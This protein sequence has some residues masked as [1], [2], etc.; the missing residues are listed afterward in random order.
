MARVNPPLI[1]FNR[2]RLSRLALARTDL[3]RTKLSAEV[4]TNF[5]PRALGSMSL[6]PGLEYIG[7]IA[8]SST[9]II[10]P[11]VFATNDTALLEMTSTKMRVWINDALVERAPSTAAVTNG[12]FAGDVTSWTDADE[13]GSTSEYYGSTSVVAGSSDFLSLV[14][15]RYARAIRQQTV[16]SSAG[17]HAVVTRVVRGRV[18]LRIGASVGGD[19]YRNEVTLRPGVY[20]HLITSTGDFTI[21]Y[22]ANT[23]YRSLVSSVAIEASGVM[24][25]DTTWASSDL[26]LLRW[27]QS[28][29]VVFVAAQGYPQK[30]LERYGPE[31][32]GVA[33]YEPQDGPFLGIN[34]SNTRLTPSAL[35]GD[36]D[37][38]ADRPFFRTEHKGALF[39]LT[40]IGQTVTA[41]SSL[42]NVFTNGIRV[43]GVGE[44][45]LFNIFI[46]STA[47]ITSTVRVQRSIGDE[48]SYANVAGL[49]YTGVEDKSTDFQD[50][51]DNQIVFYR[52]GIPTGDYV[53]TDETDV[54]L[55]YSAGGLAGVVRINNA[56]SSTQ[57]SASVLI[58]LGS[59][60]ATELWEEG[61]WSTFRG[62]PSAV[63][64][65][66][67]RLWWAGKARI[68][69][70]ISDAY[71]NFDPDEEGDGGAINKIIGSGPVDKIEW[72]GSLGTLIV[73]SQGEEL[74]AKT[75]SLEQPLTPTNFNLRDVSTQG[76]AGVPPVKIDS[77]MVFVQKSGLR[78][79]EIGYSIDALS[80]NTREVST[81]VPEIGEPGLARMA[82][83]RQP[84]TRVHCVRTST[85]G[86]VALLL[87]D[88]A[89]NITAW[90]DV[91]TGDAD[92]FNGRIEDVVILPSTGDDAVY[93]PVRR[94]ING[95]TQLYLEKMA[96][97]HEAGATPI[98]AWTSIRVIGDG[99]TTE[100]I[101]SI[102]L[103]STEILGAPVFYTGSNS[104]TADEV[105]NNIILGSYNLGFAVFTDHLDL[106]AELDFIQA[107]PRFG[108]DGSRMYILEGALSANGV[109]LV[110][111]TLST[112]WDV[113][114]ASADGTEFDI[115]A[116]E[117]EDVHDFVI[118]PDGTKLYAIG[119]A[120]GEAG[121][122]ARL[123]QYSFGT[124]FDASTLTSDAIL[125]DLGALRGAFLGATTCSALALAIGDDGQA[126]FIA[127]NVFDRLWKFEFNT[128]WDAS[129]LRFN[130]E[131]FFYNALVTRA[132]SVLF[133][134]NGLAFWL[135]D[136]DDLGRLEEYTL[137]VAWD[138][139]TAV[140]ASS[141]LYPTPS[142]FPAASALNFFFAEW[143]SNGCAL[144][145]AQTGTAVVS[146]DLP[147][148]VFQYDFPCETSAV[149]DGDHVI[150][151]GGDVG[152][153][154]ADAIAVTGDLRVILS[155]NTLQ[156][157]QPPTASVNKLVDSWKAFESTSPVVAISGADHLV[158]ET[159]YLWGNGKDLGTYTVSSTGTF[160]ASEPSTTFVYGLYYEAWFKS[161]KL[162]YGAEA[163]TALTQRKR[164]NHLG[165]ILSRTHAKGLRFGQTTSTADL[166]AM[167]RIENA[168]AISS[169]AIW[170]VY[171]EETIE[172]PGSWDSDS[173]VVLHAA[174]P[175]P[176][177]VLG[178][179]IQMDTKEKV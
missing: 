64:I 99:S 93:Y 131:N 173:R 46:D 171:D 5:M 145:F 142:S 40:S 21:E 106:T 158:G 44:S 88:K 37:L 177:T 162:A 104:D 127:D 55:D 53:G 155:Q 66:E 146:G 156:G 92:G 176:A 56:F 174:S 33:S 116:D 170:G 29:D 59:T 126:L 45:R 85:D 23:E 87:S 73:G 25:L 123:L 178:A 69:G 12:T 81:L 50:N 160:T 144:Y 100:S 102:T 11:F 103:G 70:S 169:N 34:I 82:V 152:S 76:S 62:F 16:T 13:G 7:S 91:E 77:R 75:N 32:W 139:T 84:D 124:P 3:D 133:K 49:S 1:T 80:Y 83:Q 147:R 9:C 89:E 8:N 15:T 101:D 118:K 110:Q 35:K 26:G 134:P 4:Q 121:N 2:G 61:A 79:Y 115:L 94:E 137:S 72:I 166:E 108:W 112:P 150:I 111:Y 179:I 153:T 117:L 143:R 17:E 86:T 149:A 119:T 67:G 58:D 132:T 97:E 109:R 95:S 168:E 24:V 122:R 151:S 20:S 14:G 41:H 54:T 148:I 90:I 68:W 57:S 161:M 136:S 125:I 113:T 6:R 157:Q 31:S 140:A 128:A 19:D 129:T 159:V 30:R 71:E 47:P 42:E 96:Q 10:I 65:H 38:D 120:D 60:D 167:P 43:S 135:V 114:T 22:S 164:I 105:A 18:N 141:T 63:Q 107:A 74:H 27:D 175:R 154:A 36:I 28:A 51:L 165:V 48:N 39:R 163:G 172:F 138:I 98:K 52:I 130:A 78:V